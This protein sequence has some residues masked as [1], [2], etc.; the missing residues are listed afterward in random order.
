MLRLQLGGGDGQ[1][2]LQVQESKEKLDFADKKKRK[3][4]TTV[5]GRTAGSTEA[6]DSV[7]PQYGV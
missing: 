7:E 6:A 1:T 3:E 2:E 4:F 5:L